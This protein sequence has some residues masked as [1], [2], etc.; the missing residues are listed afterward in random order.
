MDSLPLS[1][2]SIA[3]KG[4]GNAGAQIAD[5]PVTAARRPPAPTPSCHASAYSTLGRSV[6]PGRKEESSEGRSK[7]GPA[8]FYFGG[9]G[10]KVRADGAAASARSASSNEHFRARL[11]LGRFLVNV[12]YSGA[13]SAAATNDEAAHGN[14]ARAYMRLPIAS[15]NSLAAALTTHGVTLC[16]RRRERIRFR[17]IGR[18]CLSPSYGA[19]AG[20]GRS[21]GSAFCAVYALPRRTLSR[22]GV[23]N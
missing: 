7:H 3:K 21:S 23:Q 1:Y 8:A 9:F 12:H 13:L 22:S 11:N 18:P 14:H 10:P 2:L 16:A 5:S 17:R 20:A 6:S 4:D 19:L 15:M